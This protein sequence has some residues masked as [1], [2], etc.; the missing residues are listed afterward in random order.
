MEL[1]PHTKRS[2]GSGGLQ[3]PRNSLEPNWRKI[4]SI[5]RHYSAPWLECKR[6]NACM[7]QQLGGKHPTPPHHHHHPRCSS[8]AYA[9]MN[10]VPTPR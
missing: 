7:E 4:Q 8:R 9:L 10:A 2:V 5:P 6:K 1:C 3:S